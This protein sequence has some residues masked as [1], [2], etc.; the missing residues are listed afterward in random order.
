M[1]D[2]SIEYHNQEIQDLLC[3]FGGIEIV[4]QTDQGAVFFRSKFPVEMYQ[5]YEGIDHQ[6]IKSKKEIRKF[7]RELKQI[8]VTRIYSAGYGRMFL[9]SKHP[10]D[11]MSYLVV[12]IPVGQ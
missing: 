8:G 6:E 5:I 1:D 2:I 4:D 9:N 7:A 10:H 12:Q 3:Q 11:I